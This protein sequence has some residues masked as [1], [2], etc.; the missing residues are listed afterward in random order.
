LFDAKRDPGVPVTETSRVYGGVSAEDRRADRRARLVE[1]ALELVSRDRWT[2][3][4]VRGVCG[5]AGLTERYFYESF[6]D[7][8]SLLLAVF[9]RVAAE[10]AAGIVAAVDEAPHDARAKSRA[11]LSAFVSML[12]DDPRRARAMLVESMASPALRERRA[13]AVHRFA[14]L[15]RDRGREFY[16]DDAVG[17]RDAEITALALV[18]GLAE[19]VVAWLDGRI[20]VSRER[21]VDHYAE[22]FVAVSTVSSET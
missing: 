8:D 1:S 7:R 11:A 18:G 9:D 16:G 17:E 2:A 5:E 3:V 22:L 20:E 21:L 4:T 19:L 10:A 13:T 6:D 15:I 12:T 14:T